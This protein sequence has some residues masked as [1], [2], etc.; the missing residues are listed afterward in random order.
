MGTRHAEP[1]P[2]PV[3]WETSRSTTDL[4]AGQAAMFRMLPLEELAAMYQRA[5]GA[6]AILDPTG[7]RAHGRSITAASRIVDAAR[8]F[9]REVAEAIKEAGAR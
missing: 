8:R 3:G 4:L 6:G 1:E 9:E 7:F 2:E 5:E